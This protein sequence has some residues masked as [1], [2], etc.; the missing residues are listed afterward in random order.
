MALCCLLYTSTLYLDN[1]SV[2][3]YWEELK[4]TKPAFIRGYPSGIMEMCKLAMNTGIVC[5]LYTS[6]G[7]YEVIALNDKDKHVYTRLDNDCMLN[8]L[9]S[10]LQRYHL[11]LIHI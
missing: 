11:S 1:N 3:Y 4:R 10:A 8:G 9:H 6:P 2:K 5:L 7:E